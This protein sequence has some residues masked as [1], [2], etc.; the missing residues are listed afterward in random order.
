MKI[1]NRL[2]SKMKNKFY[3]LLYC[4]NINGFHA[5]PKYKYILN[6]PKFKYKMELSNGVNTSLYYPDYNVNNKKIKFL[7]VAG[8]C[9]IFC[10]FI[11]GTSY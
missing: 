9:T 6:N 7:F 2:T 3:S 10:V 1:D 5:F 4:K 11:K 8:S